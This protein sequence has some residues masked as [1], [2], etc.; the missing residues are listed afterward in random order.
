M[1]HQS[2][3][4][5]SRRPTFLL[6]AAWAATLLIASA[7]AVAQESNA[8]GAV[9]A[10]GT[11]SPEQQQAILQR[12]S[13]QSGSGSATQG[14]GNGRQG[15]GNAISNSAPASDRST[16]VSMAQQA[17]IP[18]FEPEDT[19]LLDINVPGEKSVAQR[20]ADAYVRELAGETSRSIDGAAAGAAKPPGEDRSLDPAHQLVRVLG[21]NNPYKLDREGILQLPGF[22]AI[23]LRG[24]NEAEATRRL[25]AE[26]ALQNFEIRVIRLPVAKTGVAA[27]RLYGYDLFSGGQQ[28]MSPVAMAPMPADYVVGPGDVLEVQL[29]GSQNN[30]LQ[31]TVGR[32]GHVNFPQLGPIDLGGRLYGAFQRATL[33]HA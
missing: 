2:V 26:P 12:L 21:D 30:T 33:N 24:L 18:V 23:E 7:A 11:L 3:A 20:T 25:A 17:A 5:E 15:T 8:S 9:Q 32:D 13:S 4:L 1:R 6:V 22:R 16:N 31:L 27:L 10:F 14:G 28:G 29:Y 19:V